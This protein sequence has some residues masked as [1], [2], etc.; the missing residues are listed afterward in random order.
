MSVREVGKTYCWTVFDLN[1]AHNTGNPFDTDEGCVVAAVARWFDGDPEWSKRGRELKTL[2]ER[3]NR[4]AR[5]EKSHGV[6]H[7]EL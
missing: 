6:P 3:T 7:L 5:L 1:Y 4:I 2:N